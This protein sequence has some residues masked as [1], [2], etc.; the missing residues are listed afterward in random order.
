MS[1]NKKSGGG[2][3]HLRLVDP[4][5]DP[6]DPLFVDYGEVEGPRAP[7]AK[8]RERRPAQKEPFVQIPDRVRFRLYE[9]KVG[10]AAWAC[11]M[12]LEHLVLWRGKNPLHFFGPKLGRRRL[13]AS[14]RAAALRRLEKA[15]LIKIRKAKKGMAPF[16]TCLWRPLAG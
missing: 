3:S 4:K 15:G 8:Q 16:V 7:R 1:A 11:A 2:K 6:T 10:D 5:G 9:H 13:A 14:T 12:E